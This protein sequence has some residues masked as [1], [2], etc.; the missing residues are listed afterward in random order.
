MFN[1]FICIRVASRQR[2]VKCLEYLVKTKLF[3]KL[4]E[5]VYLIGQNELRN[6]TCQQI[7]WHCL[8]NEHSCCI[9]FVDIFCCRDVPGEDILI[10][11]HRKEP[12][13]GPE[14]VPLQYVLARVFCPWHGWVGGGGG[15]G[16]GEG[17]TKAD[18]AKWIPFRS[19]SW[20]WRG[21]GGGGEGESCCGHILVHLPRTLTK[22]EKCNISIVFNL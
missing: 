18:P 9:Y 5:T 19:V 17:G 10:R 11:V 8:F 4:F 12:C 22:L 16:E 21:G 7:S 3:A 15:W 2:G 6:K 1:N 20:G 13:Q 14:W